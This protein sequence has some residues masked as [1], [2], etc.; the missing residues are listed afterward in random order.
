MISSASSNTRTRRLATRRRASRS[1]SAGA[2]RRPAGF[3]G[4]SSIRASTRTSAGR[5]FDGVFD[6]VGGA[7]RGSFN[8]RFG[9]ASR[10]A[11]AALQHPVS[12]GHVSVHR[13]RQTDPVTGQPTALLARAERSGTV[14][15]FFHLLTNSEYFNRAGSLV[16]TDATERATSS[17]PRP[18]ASTWSPPRRTSSGPFPPCRIPDRDFLGGAL[19]PLDYCARHPRALSRARRWVVD[20][21]APPPSRYPRCADGTLTPPERAGWP[22]VPGFTLPLDRR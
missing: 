5:V 10:D 14:P 17:R 8:H 15:K 6:Q 3:C 19:N 11:A 2:C 21:L 22:K 4:T 7:G 9:Q 16:H 1:P 18:A 13:R 12:R 20:G